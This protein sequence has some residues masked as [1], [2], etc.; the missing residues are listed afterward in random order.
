MTCVRD[1]R[2]V[3]WVHPFL[4]LTLATL[5]PGGATVPCHG[6]VFILVLPNNSTCM[7]K[8]RGYVV[9]HGP[10]KVIH[11]RRELGKNI[12]VTWDSGTTRLLSG[13]SQN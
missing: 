5:E 9:I 12:S 13:Q 11:C 10:G 7:S 1:H 6:V 4:V 8:L 2:Q 3:A